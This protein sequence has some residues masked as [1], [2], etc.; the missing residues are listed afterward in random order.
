ME[1]AAENVQKKTTMT[2]A[3]YT[4][5]G[6]LVGVRDS[7]TAQRYTIIGLLSMPP[8]ASLWAVLCRKPNPAQHHLPHLRLAVNDAS[9]K[10]QA[11]PLVVQ[12]EV[13]RGKR[14][15]QHAEP[16]DRVPYR[17]EVE[18]GV[19]DLRKRDIRRLRNVLR[20]W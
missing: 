11:P 1:S 15:E 3:R 4:R 6:G 17:A 5:F 16:V 19:R 12:D 9:C 18:S 20:R 2:V 8:K 7:I 14:E 10:V 13:A